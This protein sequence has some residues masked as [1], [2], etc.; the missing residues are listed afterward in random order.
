MELLYNQ[1][2]KALTAYGYRICGDA[3]LVEDAI[4]DVFVDLWRRREYLSEVQNVRFYLFRALRN[5]LNRNIRHDLFDGAEDIDDFLDYLSTLSSEQQSIE[6]EVRLSRDRTIHKALDNLSNRQ[7]EAVHLRFYQ[8]L[9]LDESA[10]LMGIPKQVVK[11][12]LSKA[13]A[14]LR[15]SLK[16]ILSLPLLSFFR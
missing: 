9:S 8:G 2:F 5:Q 4:Q 10:E 7:R 6:Q 14:V 13:Y 12:L 1:H 11:N 15:L 16:V 3:A